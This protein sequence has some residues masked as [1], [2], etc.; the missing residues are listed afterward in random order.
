MSNRLQEGTVAGMKSLS[1]QRVGLAL[2]RS[3]NNSFSGTDRKADDEG[4]IDM[5]WKSM[6]LLFRL[7]RFSY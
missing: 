7:L 4:H 1:P 2:D 6:D 5:P 3:T